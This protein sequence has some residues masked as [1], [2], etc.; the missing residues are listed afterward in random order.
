M[1]VG[2]I[3]VSLSTIIAVAD[4]QLLSRMLLY[5]PERWTR[6]KSL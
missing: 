2:V 5:V 4:G 6:R 1:N 3:A